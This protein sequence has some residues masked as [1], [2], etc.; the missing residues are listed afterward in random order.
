MCLLVHFCIRSRML[1]PVFPSLVTL[2]LLPTTHMP[3]RGTWQA[4]NA[5]IVALRILG[6]GAPGQSCWHH[7]RRAGKRFCCRSAF[8]YPLSALLAPAPPDVLPM[9][10]KLRLPAA[11][12]PPSGL[13]G[14]C[15]EITCG[16]ALRQPCCLFALPSVC[17][18]RHL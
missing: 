15:S 14:I 12:V 17:R 11:L 8:R 13:P 2:A 6:G 9:W 10:K 5:K 3:L 7:G 16:M 18:Q 4:Q 1:L